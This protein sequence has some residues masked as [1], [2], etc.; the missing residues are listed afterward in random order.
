[1]LVQIL[2]L[3]IHLDMMWDF[4]CYRIFWIRNVIGTFYV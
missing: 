1:M 4:K 2:N 3:N